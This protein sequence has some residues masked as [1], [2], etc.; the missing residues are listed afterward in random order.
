MCIRDRDD[1]IPCQVVMP[2]ASIA[3]GIAE[4]ACAKLKPNTIIQF[5]RFGF[6]RVDSLNDK[7]VA[8]YTHK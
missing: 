1:G 6:V 4:K 2:D 8:Y 7:L 5:E 3:E